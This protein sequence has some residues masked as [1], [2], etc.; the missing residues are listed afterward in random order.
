MI[1][2]P[3]GDVVEVVRIA[4]RSDAARIGTPRLS[5]RD[6]Q[7]GRWLLCRRVSSRRIDQVEMLLDRYQLLADLGQ[8][9]I[10]EALQEP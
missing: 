8:R 2:S 10:K 4:T 5:F 9:E 3:S 1:L 6:I 7:S